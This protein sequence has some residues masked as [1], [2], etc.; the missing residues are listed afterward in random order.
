MQ[1]TREDIAFKKPMLE[2]ME[3]GDN[4]IRTELA[5]LNQVM[6]HIGSSIQESVGVLGQLLS[7][8]SRVFPPFTHFQ[9]A[10]DFL[11][12]VQSTSTRTLVEPQPS[13]Q[14]SDNVNEDQSQK[15]LL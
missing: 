13:F 12:S 6:S 5:T 1:L 10:K 11:P 15:K 14:E 7:N 4:E 3:K 9:P 2:K 8:Q